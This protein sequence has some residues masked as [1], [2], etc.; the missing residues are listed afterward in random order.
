MRSRAPTT[1]PSSPRI[2]STTLFQST[3]FCG[4]GI[5]A[6][7]AGP[8]IAA[9]LGIDPE[10]PGALAAAIIALLPT[11]T[12]TTDAVRA[13]A[14]QIGLDP[15]IAL[16]IATDSDE[17]GALPSVAGLITLTPSAAGRCC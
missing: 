2:S 3:G 15:H 5:S 14:A 9:R 6:E 4:T 16:Q 1:L 8:H 11:T 17:P 13:A 7:Q 12:S 10:L